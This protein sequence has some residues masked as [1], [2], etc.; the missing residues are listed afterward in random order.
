MGCDHVPNV[1]IM[2]T[3]N[4]A[5]LRSHLS[6]YLAR[7]R[8][9]EEIL[10]RDRTLAVAKIVPLSKTENYGDELLELAAL[11]HLRLPETSLDLKSFFAL[12][13]ANIALERLRAVRLRAAFEVEVKKVDAFW[14]ARA[15][16]PL[17]V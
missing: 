12:P 9:G 5:E 10:I 4:V 3:V 7:V 11:G 2:R 6:I 16:V 1:H 8:G 15:L 14:D 13:T 17:C